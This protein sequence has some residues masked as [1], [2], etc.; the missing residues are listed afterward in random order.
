MQSLSISE[1]RLYL[2]AALDKVANREKLEET[3]CEVVGYLR[4]NASE[5]DLI[6]ERI[7]GGCLTDSANFLLR[8]LSCEK[9]GHY[10]CS[11]SQKQDEKTILFQHHSY[12]LVFTFKRKSYRI[13][14]GLVELV[15]KGSLVS[16]KDLQRYLVEN[17]SRTIHE[18]DERGMHPSEFILREHSQQLE[19]YDLDRVEKVVSVPRKVFGRFGFTKF[20][21]EKLYPV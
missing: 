6:A 11:F 3:I 14:D 12:N 21:W 1:R 4:N 5:H 15:R 7:S 19:T 8:D 17:I 18:D 9:I 16:E 2:R 13:A 10:S 20:E